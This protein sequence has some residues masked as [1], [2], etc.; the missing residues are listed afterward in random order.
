MRLV[1]AES[2]DSGTAVSVS[3]VAGDSDQEG[4]TCVVVADVGEVVATGV[5][6]AADW[7]ASGRREVSGLRLK[8]G[9]E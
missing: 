8:L 4:R 3:E 2:W 7:R 1:V 6:R 5:V 9:G